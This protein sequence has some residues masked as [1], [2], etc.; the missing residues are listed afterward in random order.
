MTVCSNFFVCLFCKKFVN[1]EDIIEAIVALDIGSIKRAP[2]KQFDRS[3]GEFTGNKFFVLEGVLPE[4]R[5]KIP[6]N[7]AF[8]VEG[9]GNSVVFVAQTSIKVL[10]VLR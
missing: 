4:N 3:T 7:F 10:W 1:D 8:N 2:Q 9:V 5:S 6:N